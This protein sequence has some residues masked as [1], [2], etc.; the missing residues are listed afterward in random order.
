MPVSLTTDFCIGPVTKAENSPSIQP[1]MSRSRAANTP[2]TFAAGLLAALD[3]A[4]AGCMDGE[5]SA[6]V[7]GPMQKSVV[8]DAGIAFSGHTEYLAENSGVEDVVMLLITDAMRVC[9]AHT[10][11]Y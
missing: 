4:I 6:L 11:L 7:T 10:H 5:F 1:A 3:R 2:A 8:N 9:L